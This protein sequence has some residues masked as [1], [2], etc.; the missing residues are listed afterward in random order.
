MLSIIRLIAWLDVVSLATRRAPIDLVALKV[1]VWS[2]GRLTIL[3]ILTSSSFSLVEET[4][5]SSGQCAPI[6]SIYVGS[7]FT[8]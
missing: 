7:G 1:L 6:S 5:G 4:H 2:R 8:A 3:Q